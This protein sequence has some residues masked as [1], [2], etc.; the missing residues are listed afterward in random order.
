MTRAPEVVSKIMLDDFK[1]PVTGLMLPRH[2]TDWPPTHRTARQR[3]QRTGYINI[4]LS[5]GGGGSEDILRFNKSIAINADDTGGYPNGA[6]PMPQRSLPP[7]KAWDD[8][9]QDNKSIS[10][11]ATTQLD[12]FAENPMKQGAGRPDVYEALK[13]MS[14][15]ERSALKSFLELGE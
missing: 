5:G 7:N 6:A 8:D 14:A 4:D 11:T 13:S 1:M 3:R 15:A 2:W 10:G 9:L 12:L